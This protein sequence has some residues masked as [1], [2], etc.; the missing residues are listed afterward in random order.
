LV[1]IIGARPAAEFLGVGQP[2]FYVVMGVALLLYGAILLWL[3]RGETV[4]RR[5]AW[6]AILLDLLW[7][8]GSVL[9]LVTGWI[10]FSSGGKWAV[11]I[12]ADIV[13]LFA[14]LQYLGIR[15]LV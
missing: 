4:D 2:L 11:A 12:V 8:G 10:A 5:V 7:V 14:L 9:L 3:N 1:F 6:L 13:A 15:R